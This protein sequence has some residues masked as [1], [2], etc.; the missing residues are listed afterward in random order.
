MKKGKTKKTGHEKVNPSKL[1]NKK[2]RNKSGYGNLVKKYSLE[3]EKYKANVNRLKNINKLVIL[4]IAIIAILGV[5]V[6]LRPAFIGYFALEEAE[7]HISEINKLFVENSSYLFIPEKEGE[8]K[9]LKL[10]GQLIGEGI[11]KVYLEAGNESYLIFDS[12]APEGGGLTGITGLA[13]SEFNEIQGT[14]ET[15][16]LNE[17]ISENGSI[18]PNETTQINETVPVN[19]S[20]NDT[21]L[22]NETITANETAPADETQEPDTS[23]PNPIT[24]L[25]VINKTGVVVLSWTNPDNPDFAGVKALRKQDVYPDVNYSK[26]IADNLVV[27]VTDKVVQTTLLDDT[28]TANLTYY[29]RI[30]SYDNSFNHAS[31][32]GVLAIVQGI[33]LNE[34]VPV[35][36]TIPANETLVLNETLNETIQINETLVLN[37]TLIN[38]TLENITN[39]PENAEILI[40]LEYNNGTLFDIDNDGIEAKGGIVDFNV[41]AEFNWAVNKSNLCTKWE[42][43]SLENETSVTVC[44]GNERCCN[45]I[46]LEPLTANWDEVF[47]SYYGRYGATSKNKISAQVVYVDYSIGE[48][49]PYSYVYY[50]EWDSLN[51]VFLEEK[52]KITQFKN[53]CI[54]T[55]VLSLNKTSY[56][57]RI[58]LE[59]A[60]LRL[61]NISCTIIPLKVKIVNNAPELLMDIPDIAISKNKEF[62]I[63][64]S[65]YFFDKDNDSL[66]YIIYE[67]DDISVLVNE[68]IAIFMPKEGFTGIRHTFIIANDSKQIAVSNVFMVNVTE[69]L[70]VKNIT[71][72]NV[73]FFNVSEIPTQLK[74]E[75]NKPVKWVK[76]ISAENSE[77][78]NKT[79][80]VYFSLPD[81]AFNISVKDINL[82]KT[83]EKDKII[84]KDKTE[85]KAEKLEIN[86][87]TDITTQ[88][89]KTTIVSETTLVNET[90]ET[91]TSPPNPTKSLQVINKTGVVIL[92]WTNPD[93]PDFA[94]VKAL[95]KQ[96]VYPDINYSKAIADSLVVDITD[97]IN[98]A[99]TLLDNTVT[100]NI[101][102][103]YRIYSYDSS[104]NYASG[105]GVL[106]TVE[107]IELN[108]TISVNESIELNETLQINETIPKNESTEL[109]E[110]NEKYLEFPDLFEAH[111]TKEYI[112]E[113]ET[114][115]PVSIEI[116]ISTYKKQVVISS[117]LHYTNVL[118]YTNVPIEV[119]PQKIR[120]YWIRND[121]REL[122]TNV[123]YYDLNNN[124]LI[125]RIEWTI[126]SLSNQTFEIEIEV[127]N[128]QSYP[129]VGGNWTVM[130]NTTGTANLTITTFN[131]TSYSEIYDDNSSTIDDLEILELRCGD[132][133][134]FNKNSL[135]NSKNLYFILDNSSLFKL[136]ET[137]GKELRVKSLFVENYYCNSTSYHTVK[138]LTPGE[139]NQEF[140]FNDQSAY[141]HN[142]ATD[143]IKASNVYYEFNC[144]KC[145]EDYDSNP[146]NFCPM[147]NHWQEKDDFEAELSFNITYVEQVNSASICAYQG[148]TWY[149]EPFGYQEVINYIEKIN[150]SQISAAPVRFSADD[151]WINK[152]M[153]VA[154]GWKCINITTFVQDSV[155]NNETNLYVRWWGQDINGSRGPVACFKGF[156]SLDQ[157]DGDNPS[158]ALDCRP[159]LD[160]T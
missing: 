150:S 139:H 115:A 111:E 28:V 32:Q 23:P 83:I 57:L 9:S 64:L 16:D 108:E 84:V 50:S 117:D 133:V 132:N 126:P 72:E 14:N 13:V 60:T 112:V 91:D 67:M 152:T 100:A 63:D 11:A 68:S 142:F 97:K 30:Y 104:L 47:Y 5:L 40:E 17:T 61:D 65:K 130:F 158:G 116:N 77:A 76:I 87:T 78:I 118:A 33:E 123:S 1:I 4:S 74:A 131:K 42:T 113:Y 80:N 59:N 46:G 137:I 41:N 156:A 2:S 85:I 122:F 10:S 155:N 157:C 31:G 70:I 34:T 151:L 120:L 54:E 20:L 98:S 141:A 103:Y 145:A 75:I 128:V 18:E 135:A 35:N 127:L 25:Q 51:A 55:C 36:K 86:E 140:R 43:Y 95:R 56:R 7:E 160:I 90:Q 45:F 19:N 29:Y 149:E 58:E 6:F 96:E 102:Y 109:N 21:K 53:I 154:L 107:G 144:P 48:E 24:T 105:Q 71:V 73:T 143:L 92:S 12:N 134:L 39:P 93:N 110:A 66:D 27:D 15:A 94:G 136:S 26:A 121:T 44:Y 138:V 81:Y 99:T 52:E 3:I 62:S 146:V 69:A 114:S 37:E 88:I 125:D 79:I 49:N 119:T 38:E 148:Y 124:S 159:Y 82:D 106:A 101:T 22:L 129:T 147:I 8:L 89:N 153:S